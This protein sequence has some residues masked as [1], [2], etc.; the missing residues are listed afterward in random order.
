MGTKEALPMLSGKCRLLLVLAHIAHRYQIDLASLVSVANLSPPLIPQSSSLP[1][2][3]PPHTPA[4]N[5]GTSDSA[6][7]GKPTGGKGKGVPP[8]VMPSDL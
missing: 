5:A 8:P 1:A 4:P 2:A 6:P 7:K 3:P